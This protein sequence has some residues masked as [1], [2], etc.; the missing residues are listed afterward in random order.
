M[1]NLNC[2]I[3]FNKV[4]TKN[5]FAGLGEYLKLLN[6]SSIDTR[7][8]DEVYKD[9]KTNPDKK[10]LFFLIMFNHGDVTNRQHNI[11]GKNKVEGGGQA[12]R[13][14]FYVFVNWLKDADYAQFI[15]FLNAGLFNQYSCFDQL[16]R[17][18]IKTHYNS[19]YV[20]ETYNMLHDGVYREDLA[21]YIVKIINGNNQFNKHLV[22][23]FL[24]LPRLS[25]RSKCKK[26]LPE[27]LRVM[28]DKAKFLKILSDKMGW[29]YAYQ[30]NYCRFDG[31]RRWRKQYNGNLESVLF[32]TNAILEFDEIEFLDWLNKTPAGARFRVEKRL[33]NNSKWA[34]LAKYFQT[35]ITH[36]EQAQAE[37]RVLEEK[38]RQGIASLDELERLIEVA[39]EAKVTTGAVNFRTL[40]EEICVNKIDWLKVESFL[41]TVKLD[42]NNFIIIDES[43]SM[44]GRPFNFAIF[45]ASIFLAKNPDDVARNMFLTFSREARL[46]T[47]I[48]KQKDEYNSIWNS[49]VK[50]ITPGSFIIPTM[51]FE[52]N[53]KRI[54]SYL[55]ATF[56][57]GGTNVASI[58][59][60]F[61][62]QFRKNPQIID[63][64]KHYSVFTI[65]SDGDFNN[66][67]NAP[68]SIE[69]F[70]KIMQE[71]LGFCPFII[72]LEITK[73]T[74]G[75]KFGNIE[76][77]MY[78]NENPAQIEQIL[79]NF[80]DMD[81]F[82]IYTPLLTLFRSNRYIPVK[83]AI[84]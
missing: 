29:E 13:E 80:K 40:F 73:N 83:N 14:A 78:I 39:K 60:F 54:S 35:W 25:R 50:D 49:L 46:H 22:A 48:D 69:A 64:L 82:D 21:D 31:Y 1:S 12:N 75:E 71:N 59:S 36:K 84:I 65:I 28:H 79:T 32:S 47:K 18:R 2:P 42:Y 70:Q 9:A 51:S 15:K 74:D 30:G 27:T 44:S 38:Q 6:S 19:T 34:K 37:K 57:S 81:V 55:R 52:Q 77:F 11:F 5:P 43:G 72:L 61:A 8:L 20:E 68:S 17:N 26:M 10:A 16:F 62:E 41:D 63:D 23:K 7:I 3:T 4:G 56:K 76:N 66:S 53:Y 24:T 45:L 33:Q 58:A 67:Y